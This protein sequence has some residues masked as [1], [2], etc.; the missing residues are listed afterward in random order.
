LLSYISTY[1][2]PFMARSLLLVMGAD[3]NYVDPEKGNSPLHV[4]AKEGQAMQVGLRTVSAAKR[5]VGGSPPNPESRTTPVFLLSSLGLLTFI[6]VKMVLLYR[7][8]Q[9]DMVGPKLH[10]SNGCP[11]S[12]ACTRLLLRSARSLRGEK[13]IISPNPECLIC[14]NTIEISRHWSTGGQRLLSD[15]NNTPPNLSHPPYLFPHPLLIL[16]YLCAGESESQ[17]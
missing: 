8:V 2:G 14:R 17:H 13:Q 12:I 6:T 7:L 3:V 15:D 5:L 16:L 1:F 11:P 9:R 10:C 4:A